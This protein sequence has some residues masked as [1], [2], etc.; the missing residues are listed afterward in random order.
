MLSVSFA[1]CSDSDTEELKKDEVKKE[2][3][4]DDE[5]DTSS[6]A[7]N[8]TETNTDTE[9]EIDDESQDDT[10]SKVDEIL[11]TILSIKQV[12]SSIPSAETPESSSRQNFELDL[13]MI[14]PIMQGAYASMNEQNEGLCPQST[15]TLECEENK[16]PVH[17]LIDYKDG[18]P[19]DAIGYRGNITID[20][21]MAV[22]LKASYQFQKE[23]EKTIVF[24]LENFGYGDISVDASGEML[25]DINT[26]TNIIETIVTGDYKVI[27]GGEE[28]DYQLNGEQLQEGNELVEMASNYTGESNAGYTF[29]IQNTVPFNV[30]MDCNDVESSVPVAYPVSGKELLTINLD[31]GEAY[32]FTIDY[33]NG[34]CDMLYTVTDQDGN[35][36]ERNLLVLE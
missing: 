1:S 11:E 4:I 19:D 34:E 31:G 32:E 27:T 15:Y 29:T 13:S 17:A 12:G 36:T 16:M 23:Y 20:F 33:G 7:D 24:G 8:E 3:V 21:D 10:Q 22:D 25:Q 2:E 9:T 6:D 28:I 30:K 35:T 26:E 5:N 14:C 18:C